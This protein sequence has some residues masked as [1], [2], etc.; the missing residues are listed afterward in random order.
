ME[1]TEILQLAG[2]VNKMSYGRSRIRMKEL[3][4]KFTDGTRVR[5]RVREMCNIVSLTGKSLRK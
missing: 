1:L 4:K 3:E 5:D 2:D